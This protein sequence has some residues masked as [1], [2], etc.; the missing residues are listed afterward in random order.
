MR[1]FGIGAAALGNLSALYFYSYAAMQVPTGLLADAWGPRRLL[2]A[3]AAVA[4]LGA[5]LLGAA[6]SAFWAGAGRFLIGGSVAVAFVGS[7]KLAS[8]WFPSSRFSVAS[9]LL[10][11]TGILG[12]VFAGVPLRLLVARFGWRPVMLVAAVATAGVGAALWWV[13]GDDP[14]SVGMEPRHP[15]AARPPARPGGLLE[16]MRVPNVRLLALAPA[17]GRSDADSPTVGPVLHSPLPDAPDPGGGLLVMPGPG[18]RRSRPG[19]VRPAGRRKAPY[20]ASCWALPGSGGS[21]SGRASR[22]GSGWCWPPSPAGRHDRFTFAKE[23]AALAA[24]R[25]RL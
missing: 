18:R 8:H 7:L 13:A 10:L 4:A 5:V 9:G 12:A 2:T 3:G 11:L 15:E 25:H 6:G 14:A 24:N 23:S 21:S 19:V 1:D 17:A 22:T 20:A 16:V